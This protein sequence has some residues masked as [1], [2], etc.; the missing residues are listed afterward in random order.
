MKSKWM[1]LSFFAVVV[2]ALGVVMPAA[3]LPDNEPSMNARFMHFQRMPAVIHFWGY[4]DAGQP[5][6]PPAVVDEGQPLL[7][8]FEW[9]SSSVENLQTLRDDP[10]HTFMVSV[11]GEEPVSV[12]EFYQA[13]FYAETQSG[14]AW[15]WD[16]DGDGPGDGDGDGIGDWAGPTMFFRYPHPGMGSGVHTF[17]FTLS[18]PEQDDQTETITVV[19]P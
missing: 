14:A 11:D 7:F 12:K 13:P 19:V 6:C 9:V 1:V 2:L 5:G 15:T 10:A 8:G 18:F 16:H 3:A 4:G 17:H